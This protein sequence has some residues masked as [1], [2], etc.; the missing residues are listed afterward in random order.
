MWRW[1]AKVPRPVFICIR[2]RQRPHPGMNTMTE[3]EP[4]LQLVSFVQLWWLVCESIFCHSDKMPEKYQ[5]QLLSW[6]I[7]SKVS[8][9]SCLAA[10]GPAERKRK[11]SCSSVAATENREDE[12]RELEIRHSLQ[13]HA[14]APTSFIQVLLPRSPLS[15]E[16]IKGSLYG[17]N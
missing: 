13:S 3:S 17:R 9:H 10:S 16:L 12:R 2:R 8:V 1:K 4:S 15:Y 14:S 11:Q 6:I 5:F 7:V